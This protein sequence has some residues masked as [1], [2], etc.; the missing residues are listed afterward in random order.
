MAAGAELKAIDVLD[1]VGPPFSLYA[2]VTKTINTQAD[3]AKGTP[4]QTT[5]TSSLQTN[6]DQSAFSLI[7]GS[8]D[9]QYHVGNA[10]GEKV[11]KGGQLYRVY[12]GQVQLCADAK[13]M[14]ESGYIIPEIAPSLPSV[15]GLQRNVQAEQVRA[16]AAMQSARP[17]AAAA[18]AVGTPSPQ[19]GGGSKG[20]GAAGGAPSSTGS[21]TQGMTAALQA[22]RVSALVNADGCQ[23]DEVVLKK[24]TEQEFADAFKAICSHSMEIS[25]GD[26]RFFRSHPTVQ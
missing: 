24:F 14:K 7:T 26:F 17:A 5:T 20:A 16:V 19:A 12:S 6:V 22:G 10:D 8:N 11:S 2:S 1:P 25:I 18:N 4:A 21:S 15:K 9:G 13:K 3:A 23:A